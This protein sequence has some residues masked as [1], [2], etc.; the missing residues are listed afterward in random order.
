VAIRLVA[1][2]IVKIISV[3]ST[4]HLIDHSTY[5]YATTME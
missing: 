1:L 2:K 3:D 4:A 5:S